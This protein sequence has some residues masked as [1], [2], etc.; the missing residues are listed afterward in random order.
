M[1]VGDIGPEAVGQ[2]LLEVWHEDWS[3]PGQ[4]RLDF[5]KEEGDKVGGDEG[6]VPAA[7]QGERLSGQPLLLQ[8]VCVWDGTTQKM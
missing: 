5:D 1:F 3:E 4:G 2:L 6:D 8:H 7:T